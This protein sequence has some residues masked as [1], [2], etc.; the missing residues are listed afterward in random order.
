MRVEQL[1]FLSLLAAQGSLAAT[2]GQLS[3]TGAPCCRVARR[4]SAMSAQR[5][6]GGTAQ[7]ASDP[8]GDGSTVERFGLDELAEGQRI[9]FELDRD[10]RLGKTTA[11]NLKLL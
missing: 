1:R 4:C 10:P 2:A 9:F 3:M 11:T 6:A 7:V 5:G 8:A